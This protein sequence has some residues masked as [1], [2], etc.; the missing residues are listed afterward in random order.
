MKHQIIT[1]DI[2]VN[3][4]FEY[5]KRETELLEKYQKSFYGIENYKEFRKLTIDVDIKCPIKLD[6]NN[7]NNNRG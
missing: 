4:G 3:A 6:I 1:E 7:G 2:L 5:N